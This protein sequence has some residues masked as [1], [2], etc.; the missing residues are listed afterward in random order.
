MPWTPT[1]ITLKDAAGNNQPVIAY[2]DG[3]NYSLAHPLLDATGAIVAPAN[4]GNQAAGNSS[5]TTI[6]ANTANIPAKGAATSA[7]SVPVVIA[8]DQGSLPLPTGAATAANQATGNA[9][10]ATIATNTSGVATAANQT[11]ANTSLATIATNTN[12]AAT[13]SNQ[14][15]GNTSL[16]SLDT[17]LGAKADSSASTDT[18]TFSLIALFKRALQTLTTISGA[19]ATAANQST[20]ITALGAPAD[21]AVTNPASSASIIA[22]LK[23]ILTGVNAAT[24]AGANLIGSVVPTMASGGHTSVTTAATGTNWTAFASQAL[25]QLTI[26]NQTGVTLEFRQGAA[27]VG[28]PIPTSAF[29][30][31]FGLTNAN[32]IDVRR[33]DTSNT[34][35]TVAARWES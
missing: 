18:G 14:T 2:T 31:F 25:K 9:S 21:A 35:V 5:L 11:T 3:T 26:S 16:G 6:V 23:G 33:V 22:A 8:S 24:P 29:Y 7:N 4:A 17:N 30:T 19:V 10:L 34:Q 12:G 1:T 28:L 20:Q 15:T 32:Q 13:A 27:G